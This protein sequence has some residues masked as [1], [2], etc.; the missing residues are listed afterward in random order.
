MEGVY[1]GTQYLGKER[2]L[3]KYKRST[4]GIQRKNECRSKKAEE[5]RYG[6]RKRL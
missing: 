4:R 2:R 3:R 5:A 6:R 1:G